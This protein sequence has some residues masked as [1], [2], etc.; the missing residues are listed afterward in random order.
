M[1]TTSSESP[2]TWRNW[3]GRLAT[4]EAEIRFVRSEADAA[5]VAAS[6]A[7]AGRTVRVTGS[8]HSHQPLVLTDE[9]IVDVSGLSGVVD[10]DA[11]LDAPS[12]TIRAGTPIHS[13]GSALH[14]DGLALI[15]QGDI[16]R[17]MVG[18]AVATGTHGTGHEL[19][20]FSAAVL[21][22]RIAVASGEMVA[23][24]AE[25]ERELWQAARLNLGALGIVT[26]LTLAVRPAYRLKESGFLSTFDE[27]VPEIG[28][29]SMASR[30]FEFFWYP[31]KDR[32]VVKVIDE[33]A[34]EPVYP[35]AAEGSRV[36]WNYEVLPNHRTWPHT[37][38]EYS[39]A[40]EDGPACLT[41]IRELLQRDFPE[42]GWPV[43]Y[44]TLAA[45]D[46]WLSTA[47]G[48]PTVTISL[49]QD[50]ADDDEPLY[51]AAEEIF[52]S[53]DG[54]PHWGK[55]NYLDADTL[56]SMYPRWEEWWAVRDRVDPTGVFC[57]NYLQ[58][59]RPR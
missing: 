13:V 5:A 25:I 27:I 19:G 33:T 14:A 39:V 12:A 44:R 32:A 21:G 51:R 30:H 53:F 3:S 7:A 29:R 28:E 18:G 31:T 50:V 37:E 35:L 38:M 57:N 20:S 40:A 47:Y 52:R 11:D 46:V 6:A 42:M 22:A 36:G 10:V 15:N 43:E 58:S 9:T 4:T 34:D 54:R 24:S 23:C 16:D 56:A 2:A 8:G 59:I 49:H 48:R 26:E 45:D 55:I 17:Q 1:S 41:A